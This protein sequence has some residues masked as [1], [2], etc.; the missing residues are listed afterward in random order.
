[1]VTESLKYNVSYSD[2]LNSKLFGLDRKLYSDISDKINKIVNE[3]L[4]YAD[5][6]DIKIYDI[7]LVGSNASYNYNEDSDLDIHIVTDLS[8]IAN[9]EKIA[10]LYLDTIKR[11]FKEDYDIKIK[12]IDVELYVE[13]INSS[14]N[15]NG[16]Y[17]VTDDEWIKFPVVTEY[18]SSEQIAQA[19]EIEEAIIDIINRT[20]DPD[21]LDT[22]LDS[23]Y[24][25]RKDALLTDGENS[26]TNI[27]FKSLRNKG[28]LNRTNKELNNKIS[29]NLS[30][31]GVNKNMIKV[32]KES[33]K[34][35][36]VS[37]FRPFEKKDYYGFAGATKIGKDE[38]LIYTDSNATIIIAGDSDNPGSSICTLEVYSEEDVDCAY[39]VRDYVSFVRA[40]KLGKEAVKA[41]KIGYDKL[42]EWCDEYLKEY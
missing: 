39:T 7:R 32:I 6:K 33:Y 4:E 25:M 40:L 21:D 14:A 18:P 5:V 13:D 29:K 12:G 26:P 24:L 28:I 22:I 17:S 19:E 37:P 31:E 2:K 3:F 1:M 27:A 23:I 34:G 42:I 10:R 30:L 38:P 15:S 20:N 41:S 8:K 35:L 36:D 16:I 11:D 9:P